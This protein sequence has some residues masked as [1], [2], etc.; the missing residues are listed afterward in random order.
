M[1][2]HII[3]NFMNEIKKSN[4]ELRN[5]MGTIFR[6]R[7]INHFP[8]SKFSISSKITKHKDSYSEWISGKKMAL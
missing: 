2:A 6:K 8:S 5:Y 3:K 7:I 1:K 4:S